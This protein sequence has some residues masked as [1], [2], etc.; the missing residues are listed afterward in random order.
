M[1]TKMCLEL[2]EPAVFSGGGQGKRHDITVSA[3][4]G[5]NLTSAQ[6]SIRK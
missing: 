2:E 4:L 1:S 3:F 6:T 5:E